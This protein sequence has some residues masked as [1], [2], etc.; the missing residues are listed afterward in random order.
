MSGNRT[1]DSA[2][3]ALRGRIGGYA[4]SAKHDP[5]E[6]TAKARAKF[7][8]N[9]EKA[10]DPDGSLPPDERDRRARQL[11]QAHFAR[12]AYRSAVARQKR[13]TTRLRGK[14]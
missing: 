5:R 12:L 9:F 13:R 11:R 7:L 6:T 1:Y 3:M 2:R 14:S 10:A 4:T 8:S